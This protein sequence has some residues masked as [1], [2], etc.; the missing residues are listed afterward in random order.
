MK[1]DLALLSKYDRPG[2]RYTSYPTAVE[3]SDQLGPD[4]YQTALA[5]GARTRPLSVYVHQP[6]CRSLCHSCACNVLISS[7][8]SKI[9]DYHSLLLGEIALL[10]P[11]LEGRTLTQLHWG[12][13]TPSYLEP[14]QI[15]SLMAPFEP[16]KDAE[17]SVEVDPRELDDF[18]LEALADSGF[19]RISMGVQDFDP[20][21]QKA[22]NRIQPEPLT[23]WAVEASRK[24]GMQSVNLDL[25]YGLPHQTRTRFERTVE[26]LLDLTPDRIALYSFAHLPWLKQHHTIIDADALPCPS[27]K[28]AILELAIDRLTEA[29]YRYIGMDHFALPEDELALALDSGTLYRNFQGYSTHAGTDLVGFGMTAIGQLDRCYVQ[30]HKTLTD[31]RCAIET[32]TPATFRGVALTDDDVV[33]RAVI[34]ELMCRSELRFEEIEKRFGLVFEESFAEEL[35]DLSPFYEDGI[36]EKTQ[37]GFHLTESGRLLVRNVAMTFDSYRREPRQQQ[38]SR[39]I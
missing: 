4:D 15:R 17:I 11:L 2:P 3:F 13:G 8:R 19:N 25:I 18:R 36:I 28:L 20:T 29:G 5:E 21:V 33:R 27:E 30:N 35:D 39:T 37:R 12:G 1:V 7:N 10:S 9:A 14:D 34:M 31:Y 23:R 38:F 26:L 6:Y 22:I 16:A 24:L 32:G